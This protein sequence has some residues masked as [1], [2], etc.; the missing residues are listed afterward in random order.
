MVDL[1]PGFPVAILSTGGE[2]KV[3]TVLAG[4]DLLGNSLP[5]VGFDGAPS[6]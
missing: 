3:G 2:L 1:G 5:D 6:E 4:A